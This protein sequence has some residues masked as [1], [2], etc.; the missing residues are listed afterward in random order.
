MLRTM[1]SDADKLLNR[2]REL[3]QLDMQ[4]VVSHVQRE[5]GEWVLNTL[6]LEGYDVQFR[7]SRKNCNVFRLK[8]RRYC[9]GTRQS[10][11]GRSFDPPLREDSWM[12]FSAGFAKQRTCG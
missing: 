9:A 10:L 6:I 1:P 8:H 5:P 11:N 3:N 7:Y 2:N 12:R 4:K